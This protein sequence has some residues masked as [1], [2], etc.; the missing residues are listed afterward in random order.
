MRLQLAQIVAF[1]G[2]QASFEAVHDVGG[3]GA[4][5]LEPGGFGQLPQGVEVGVGGVAVEQDGDGADQQ[6]ADDEVPHHPAGRRVPEQAVA[7]TQV[8][9]QAEDLTCSRT[10][11]PWLC[12]RALGRPV[13]PDEYSTHSG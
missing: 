3:A 5:Q 8:G 10:T 13:V 11:P 7:R 4:E 1:A 2:A 12:T 9:V 6:A